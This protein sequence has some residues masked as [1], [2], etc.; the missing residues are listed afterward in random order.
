LPDHPPITT[1]EI[2]ERAQAVE[3]E[4]YSSHDSRYREKRFRK[5]IREVASHHAAEL[6]EDDRPI[7]HT[8]LAHIHASRSLMHQ[9]HL[10]KRKLPQVADELVAS[11]DAMRPPPNP[12]PIPNEIIH[13]YVAAVGGE[14]A[15][16]AAHCSNTGTTVG[17]RLDTS[18]ELEVTF[19]LLLEILPHFDQRHI[20]VHLNNKHVQDKIAQLPRFYY[21]RRL[22][23]HILWKKLHFMLRARKNNTTF[24][25]TENSNPLMH[26]AIV[27]SKTIAQQ[28]RTQGPSEVTS[29]RCE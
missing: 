8:T 27:E 29:Q 6:M 24:T 22:R 13:L 4:L 21:H 23:K 3:A 14:Q 5:R 20:N 28:K 7:P 19:A 18:N 1:A 9:I 2:Y 16:G 25:L 10:L 26:I 11:M 12:I 17:K 15:G